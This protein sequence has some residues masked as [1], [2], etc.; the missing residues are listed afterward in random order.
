MKTLKYKKWYDQLIFK[1]KSLSVLRKNKNNIGKYEEH[2]II[3]RCIGGDDTDENRV[4]LLAREHYIAHLLLL[5]IYES[6]EQFYDLLL[7]AWNNM[8]VKS[9]NQQRVT[10]K[11][12]MFQILKQKVGELVSKNMKRR[13]N[14]HHPV[15]NE[16]KKVLIDEVDFYIS[17]GF[18]RGIPQYMKDA[19]SKSNSGRK[20]TK[21]TIEKRMSKIRGRKYPEAGKKISEKMKGRKFSDEHRKNLSKSLKGKKLSKEQ[22]DALHSTTKGKKR[23]FNEQL[24]ESKYVRIDQIANYLNNGWKLGLSPTHVFNLRKAHHYI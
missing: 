20:Q 9:S 21:E 18:V 10:S 1:R 15:T 2:H 12:K 23:M 3:P 24:N 8:T 6:N 4:I 13:V 22:S 19:V 7:Y 17:I 14:M 5:K 11:N 16:Y